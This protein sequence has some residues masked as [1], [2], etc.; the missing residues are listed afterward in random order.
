MSEE[1][2]P[3]LGGTSASRSSKPSRVRDYLLGVTLLLLVVGLWTL[4]S[5]ITSDI[6]TGDYNSLSGLTFI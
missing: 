4:G 3:L 5:F 2:G 6:E 1:S